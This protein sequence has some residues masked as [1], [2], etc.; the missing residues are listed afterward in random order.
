MRASLRSCGRGL[1]IDPRRNVII[2]IVE[3]CGQR[4]RHRQMP[5]EK[6]A[7]NAQ[8]GETKRCAD[9]VSDG[10]NILVQLDECVSQ[11]IAGSIVRAEPHIYF[12]E[13]V[14]GSPMV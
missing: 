9:G 5:Q 13:R 12:Y 8:A 2:Q 1:P 7:V 6:T 3:R 11:S 10:I 14:H 4:K